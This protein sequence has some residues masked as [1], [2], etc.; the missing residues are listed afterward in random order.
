[1]VV[2]RQPLDHHG[3]RLSRF[4]GRI[5]FQKLGIGKPLRLVWR[6]GRTRG[7]CRRRGCSGSCEG[8]D[9]AALRGVKDFRGRAKIIYPLRRVVSPDKYLV[10]IFLSWVSTLHSSGA[11]CQEKRSYT[12][13]KIVQGVLNN[14]ADVV[15]C[16]VNTPLSVLMVDVI[17]LWL[18]L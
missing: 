17:Q 16:L 18:T 12:N 13:C 15:G 2:D 7:G 9:A 4:L 10:S 8:Q 1:M 5:L 3:V 14:W 6:L 11:L